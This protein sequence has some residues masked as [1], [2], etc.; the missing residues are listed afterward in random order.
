MK[1]LITVLFVALSYSALAQEGWNDVMPANTYP[2]LYGVYAID[3]DNVWVVGEDGTL[4]KTTDSGINWINV[5]NNFTRNIKCVEFI[6]PDT[7]WIAGAISGSS[8]DDDLIYRTT[9]GG[10]TWEQQTLDNGVVI[11]IFDIEFIR[12]SPIDPVRG[13]VAGGLASVF[14]TDDYGTT[15]EDLSGNCGEG[16]FWSC[17]FADK[18][19]GWFVGMPSAV[20]Y[21]T[22]MYT[23]DGGTTFGAQTNPTNP[24]QPLRGVCFSNT[25]NGIAVGLAYTILFTSDGGVNWE[26]RPTTCSR[27]NSVYLSETGKAW[28]V[29][30]SGTIAYSTD[31]GYTWEVQESGVTSELWEVYFINDDEGW[32]VGGGIGL[33]GVILHTTNGG[34]I[35][36]VDDEINTVREFVLN[37]NFPN[38]FNP[39]TKINYQIPEL[40]F[41]TIKVYNV[42]GNEVTTLVNEEKPAG[43]YEVDFDASDLTS[44]IYFYQLRI[45]DFSQTKK[46]VFLK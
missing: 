16:N 14:K 32:I 28:A 42:L 21:Y 37:Q 30:K 25:Q 7:G 5:P 29:G 43:G 41:V 38:P 12:D 24:E 3:S 18:N 40:S 39:T 22:I 45:S 10:I 27:W 31:W 34:V 26:E 9:D 15:W 1:L 6:N 23:T 11:E 20:N 13:F 2:G 44:G 19:H 33:P 17:S 35:T 46:M 4:I 36:D 8:G